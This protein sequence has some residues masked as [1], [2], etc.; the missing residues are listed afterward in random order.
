MRRATRM[1][2]TAL[3]ITITSASAI[4]AGAG[5]LLYEELEAGLPVG[6]DVQDANG[7]GLTWQPFVTGGARGSASLRYVAGP[8]APADDW[9]WSPV[10]QVVPGQQY[11][12][13]F[14][15]RV[16]SANHA[17]SLEVHSVMGTKPA[18]PGEVIFSDPK[19]TNQG[20][21]EASV[22]FTAIGREHR[23][24]FWCQSEADRHA[25]FIDRVIVQEDTGDLEAQAFLIKQVQTGSDSYTSKE[26]MDILVTVANRSGRQI[27]ANGRLTVGHEQNPQAVLAFRVIGPDGLERSFKAR[28]KRTLAT[29]SDFDTL[30]P[31]DSI[32]KVYDLNGGAY[33]LSLPGAYTITAVYEN[34]QSNAGGSAWL[35][36]LVADP[37]KLIVQ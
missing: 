12:L 36:E 32:F 20:T 27:V 18:S 8:G 29:E 10:L 34:V 16:T 37:I 14:R 11:T 28:Y 24:G 6:W 17:H 4:A 9:I 1:I 13:R 15:Y 3:V 2:V 22:T 21:L 30:A 25:I 7:D 26:P 35:G 19:I 23:I 31:G 33:D 5:Y